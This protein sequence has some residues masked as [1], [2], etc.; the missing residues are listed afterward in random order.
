[1]KKIIQLAILVAIPGLT[2][3]CASIDAYFADRGRD[4]ADIVTATVGVGLG[5]K[6]RIGPMQTGFLFELPL[7]GMRGG[8][9]SAD[10]DLE[11]MFAPVSTVS[12]EAIGINL[13]EEE[14]Y[15]VKLDRHKKFH[16]ASIHIGPAEGMFVYKVKD[17]YSAPYYYTQIEA[18]IA[19]GPSLRLGFNP[20]ELADFILGWTFID[21]FNDDLEQRKKKAEAN[22]RLVRTLVP[23]AAQS[24]VGH[25]YEILQDTTR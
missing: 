19:L 5:A 18:V 25:P 13:G 16:T 3:G 11:T 22:N 4:A 17:D 8:E 21:I 12:G 23:R 7:I 1:M 20:G 24:Y 2:T 15:M 6:G 10:N 9:F 14:F